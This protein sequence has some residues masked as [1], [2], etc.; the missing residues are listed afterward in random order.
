MSLIKF[1]IFRTVV[2]LGSLSKAAKTLKLTQSA[3]SHAIASLEADF[4]FT[5]LIRNRS[6][7]SLTE[8]GSEMLVY[9]Q[10][11]L[12]LN[13]QML[14]KA[15]E[16]NG[17]ETGIVRIG[18]FPSVSIQWIPLILKKFS[19]DFPLIKIK[20]Y[21]GNYDDI[22]EWI[23]EGKIDFGFLS[24]PTASSFDT[25]PIITDPLLCI[26]PD[27]HPLFHNELIHYEQ[28]RNEGFIMPKS[29][30]D[31]DVSRIFK[32]Y[33]ITPPIQ[34]EIEEDQAIISM[35]QN[36]LGISI[37]PSMILYRLPENIRAIPLEGNYSRSIG[38]AATSFKHVS[39]GA[40][41]LI[42]CIQNWIY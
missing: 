40:K 17:I 26:V 9:M 11:M 37:L 23:S 2:E 39:P 34:Y 22:T 30:I 21:E 14:Q 6:G 5:L 20:L 31:N 8:N 33:K 25:I 4:G 12:K 19:E 42:Q 10:G 7:T 16:F 35:V 36:G 1:E 41:K 15:S 18:T 3:V 13:E 24:L 28:L 29:T 38:I 32:K 27:T